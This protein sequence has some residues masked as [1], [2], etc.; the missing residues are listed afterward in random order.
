M[1]SGA[2]AQLCVGYLVSGVAIS[3]GANLRCF[4]KN[5]TLV[6]KINPICSELLLY[7]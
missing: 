7:L 4:N 6:D 3:L 2:C 5:T 1:G